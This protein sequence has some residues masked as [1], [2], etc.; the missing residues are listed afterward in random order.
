VNYLATSQ[1]EKLAHSFLNAIHLEVFGYYPYDHCTD[2]LG[3]LP[4]QAPF[5]QRFRVMVEILKTKPTMSIIES[6]NK[7]SR[8]S[9]IEHVMVLGEYNIDALDPNTKAAILEFRIEYLDKKSIA[10]F[11][12]KSGEPSET[13]AL[14]DF[15][16]PALSKYLEE[17]SKQEIPDVMKKTAEKLDLQAWQ[18]FEHAT[19]SIFQFCFGYTV[20]KLGSEKLFEH[21]PEGVVLVQD[22]VGFSFIYECKT[23]RESYHM[24]SDH[25]I[26]YCD[27]I[28]KKKPYVKYLYNCELQYY[29]IIAPSFSG[30]IRE[31][32]EQI[33][34]RTNVL[35]V[36]LPSRLL[37]EL[38]IWA[39]ALPSQVKRL[40]DLREIFKISDTEVSEK[41]VRDYMQNFEERTR[42]R[43]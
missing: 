26:R 17:L 34:Q 25:G 38:A 20:Q 18:I 29:V 6:F 31:R 19:Y 9:E 10:E 36:F 30:N 27:Y 28:E 13:L 33:H 8:A 42:H 1:F 37:S 39:C 23:A 7:I 43:Y 32:R 24:T 11:V 16:A 15:G 22:H 40:L 5:K 21:E 12:R 41:S 3:Y 4:P 35:A 14:E 2:I